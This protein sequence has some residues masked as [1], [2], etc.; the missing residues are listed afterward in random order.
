MKAQELLIHLGHAKTGT[1][2]LQQTFLKSSAYLAKNDILFPHVLPY[3]GNGLVLGYH[4]FDDQ[5]DYTGRASWLKMSRHQA[6]Q[7]SKSEWTSIVETV[8][9]QHPKTLL[10][11]SEQFFGLI[12]ENTIKRF[13][14]LTSE[15][16]ETKIAI[17]YLRA[18][19]DYFLSAIQQ[20]LKKI[21]PMKKISGTR[22]RDRLEPLFAG[23]TGNIRLQAFDRKEMFDGDIVTD[24]LSKNLP[25]LDQSGLTRPV[26]DANTSLS[27][28]AMSLLHDCRQG[29]LNQDISPQ[30]M[31]DQIMKFD[32]RIANPTKPKLL[33]DIAEAV[34]NWSAPDLFW[35]RDNRDFVF[36]NVDYDTVEITQKVRDPTNFERIEQFCKV[37][38]DRKAAIYAIAQKRAKMPPIVRRWL[39]RW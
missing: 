9:K 10:L 26:H 37:N 3:S 17:A 38:P 2:T 11:S 8:R 36:P 1:T 15:V 34:L 21:R 16:A 30:A 33:P 14:Q 4:L 12:D 25:D 29:R 20:N 23:W 24:F 35:L 5:T 6:Q 27:A 31:I 7:R 28:E 13:D 18:P 22:L 32:Q 19:A 39:A